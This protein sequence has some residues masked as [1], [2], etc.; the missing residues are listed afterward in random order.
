[1]TT[2]D[3]LM[4]TT[5]PSNDPYVLSLQRWAAEYAWIDRGIREE[6]WNAKYWASMRDDIDCRKSP[7]SV[8]SLFRPK[9]RHLQIRPRQTPRR[10]LRRTSNTHTNHNYVYFAISRFMQKKFGVYPSYPQVWDATKNKDQNLLAED[11]EPGA[12]SRVDL[13]LE[14]DDSV[15]VG[16]PAGAAIVGG[17]PCAMNL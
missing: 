7:V 4:T 5:T 11:K 17:K 12:P 1:M 16:N 14:L 13:A 2:P 8:C 3:R 10:K 15:V 9:G 6:P